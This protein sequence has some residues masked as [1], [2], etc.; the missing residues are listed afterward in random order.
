MNN[1][2]TTVFL[3]YLSAIAYGQ[4]N[5]RFF[6]QVEGTQWASDSIT[7]SMLKNEIGFG[8]S[9]QGNDSLTS[10]R[11]IWTFA[12]L[13]TIEKCNVAMESNQFILECPYQNDEEK[14][15]L[16]LLIDDHPITFHYAAVSSGSFILFY[17]KKR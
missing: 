4:P 1:I 9:L 11:Y 13:L 5:G 2:L 12:D 3:L 8:L 15:L 7:I 17:K 16:T 14:K 10:T 6:N